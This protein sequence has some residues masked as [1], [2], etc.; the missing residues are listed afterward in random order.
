MKIIWMIIVFTVATTI[1]MI[2]IYRV[3]KKSRTYQKCKNIII[4]IIMAENFYQKMQ[5]TIVIVIIHFCH[6]WWKFTAII[7]FIMIFLIFHFVATLYKKCIYV[8]FPLPS[9]IFS[10]SFSSSPLPLPSPFL[11]FLP[12]FQIFSASIKTQV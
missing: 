5:N 3:A 7:V 11:L 12:L 10:S 6:F 9:H 1:I 4:N 8:F 2:I